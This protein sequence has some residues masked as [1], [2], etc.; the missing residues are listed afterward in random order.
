[1]SQWADLSSR[2]VLKCNLSCQK[3]TKQKKN[4]FGQFHAPWKKLKKEECKGGTTVVFT[5]KTS[6]LS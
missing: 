5:K 2:E 3:R 1:M 6:I 4:T